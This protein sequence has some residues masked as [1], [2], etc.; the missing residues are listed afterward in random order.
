M[1]VVIS[2]HAYQMLVERTPINKTKFQKVV[3]KAWKSEDL[4]YRRLKEQLYKQK[5]NHNI[6]TI[7]KGYSGRIYIFNVVQSGHDGEV[8]AL[9]VTMY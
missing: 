9:L 1:R 2:D 5:F 3:E 4:N 7:I 6:N 8:I